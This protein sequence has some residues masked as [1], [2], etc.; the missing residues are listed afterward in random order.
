MIDTHAHVH[1]AKFDD[2]RAATIQRARDAG[3]E[4]IVT[5]GCDLADSTRALECARAYGLRASIGI[6]P[7]EAIGAPESID[8]AFD[9]LFDP[10]VHVA[11][12]E[13]GLDYYYD[14]SPR[15]VQR[16]VLRKQLDY[17]VRRKLP[18]IFHQRDAFDDFVTELRAGF[19]RSLGGV[20]HCFTGDAAQARLL[21]EE[22]G[23]R[24]GIGGVLTF[25]SAESLRE[26]VR[27]VGIEAL[28][29]ETDCPYLAPVPMRGRRNEPAFLTYT[30][31][32]LAEV[33]DISLDEVT[34]RTD[35]NARALFP[36][37]P[38]SARR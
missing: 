30:A 2:D 33:L 14:N 27:T 22:F 6:H 10:V 25:K 34:E 11:V 31:M 24:L 20:V 13:I 36:G 18:T 21:V 15:D 23:L 37:L 16:E 1:D 17:A 4:E 7:H 38:L 5:V 9:E 35:A 28:V 26:A 3:I 8:R 32:R 12:G 19:D 29:V